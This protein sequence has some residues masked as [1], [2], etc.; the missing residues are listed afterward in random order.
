M[1]KIWGKIVNFSDNIPAALGYKKQDFNYVNHIKDIMPTTIAGVHDEL[2][3]CMM[4]QGNDTIINNIRTI[5]LKNKTNFLVRVRVCIT[6]NLYYA[7]ELPFGIFIT[8]I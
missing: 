5:F 4:T 8:P 6:M 7:D 2:I 3:R 1:G